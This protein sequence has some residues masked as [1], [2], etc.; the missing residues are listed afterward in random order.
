MLANSIIGMRARGKL[1]R[2][3]NQLR[4]MGAAVMLYAGENHMTYPVTIDQRSKGGKSWTLTL[5]PYTTTTACYRCPC[6]PVADRVCTYMMNDFLTPNPAGARDLDYSRLASL[7]EPHAT[8]LF[9][10]ATAAWTGKDHFHFSYH[11][12]GPVPAEI[13][14]NDVAVTGHVGEA[15]YLFADGHVES[16]PW[17]EVKQRLQAGSRFVDPR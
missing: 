11:H 7:S 4:Q 16:L 8:F 17:G 10:E 1:M 13:F 12:G 9:A 14:A 15:N 5:Q 3:T 2:C 6:D